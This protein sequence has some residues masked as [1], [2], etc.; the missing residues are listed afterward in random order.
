MNLNLIANNKNNIM[1][2]HTY[3]FIYYIECNMN[4]WLRVTK[5]RRK[6]MKFFFKNQQET[7]INSND[8]I[9]ISS[10]ISYICIYSYKYI[11]YMN[12]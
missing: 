9:S 10:I 3:L 8:P 4:T 7:A 1:H 11:I 12:R 2:L 5:K 6:Q